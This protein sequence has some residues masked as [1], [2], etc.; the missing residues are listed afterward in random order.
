MKRSRP[1]VAGIYLLMM[2][3]LPYAH[4]GFNTHSPKSNDQ[5][6]HSDGSRHKHDP[7]TCGLCQ[8]VAM[9][10]ESYSFDPVIEITLVPCDPLDILT[11]EPDSPFILR[12]RARAP[13]FMTA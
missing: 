13:P 1:I 9:P 3:V 2:V 7:S 4:L 12:S 11:T 8:L 6:H 5:T 10:V